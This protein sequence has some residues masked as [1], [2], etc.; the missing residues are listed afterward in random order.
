MPRG[1]PDYSNV[2]AAQPL[3]RLDDM[4]EL[5]ARLGSPSTHDRSGS[6]VYIETFSNGLGSWVK[7]GNPADYDISIATDQFRHGP[8]SCKLTAGFAEEGYA[9]LF[10]KFPYP[11][12]NK[13]GLEFSVKMGADTGDFLWTLA[14][15]DGTYEH[16]Y[17]MKY[18]VS[19]EEIWIKGT[20]GGY[21]PLV[22]DLPLLFLYSPFHTI[23]MVVDL[24]NDEFVRL[25]VNE[26][27]YPISEYPAYVFETPDSPNVRIDLQQR[28]AIEAS[29]VSYVDDIILTQNEP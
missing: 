26:T 15:H 5:A 6:V 10:R 29:P 19:E 3:H 25:I 1:A 8:F 23:K 2:S 11:V 18:M 12:L 20:G 24:P 7:A 22:E 16:S 27:N 13:Y 4:A 21:T 28:T 14:Y 9:K 17:T